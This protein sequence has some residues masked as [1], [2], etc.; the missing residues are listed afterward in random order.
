MTMCVTEVDK[1]KKVVVAIESYGVQPAVSE[2][3]FEIRHLEPIQ[4]ISEGTETCTLA[5]ADT[6]Q[7]WQDFSEVNHWSD[8]L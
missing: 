7:T 4:L 1:D 3:G 6:E 5:A 2:E 8:E